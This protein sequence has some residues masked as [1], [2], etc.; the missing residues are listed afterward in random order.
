MF[1]R[2]KQPDSV[3]ELRAAKKIEWKP[4][5]KEVGIGAGALIIFV[6]LV[7]LLYP[8]NRSLPYAYVGTTA[9]GYRTLSEVQAAV[10]Q[11]FNSSTVHLSAQRVTADASLSSLGASLNADKTSEEI[12]SY[13]LWQRLLPFSILW[14]RPKIEKL[15]VSFDDETLNDV[16]SSLS[17]KLVAPSKN[18]S[19]AV[20]DNGDISLVS[21]EEGVSVTDENVKKAVKDAEYSIGVSN[22]SVTPIL[23]DPA[24]TNDTVGVVKSKIESILQKNVTIK[25]S[26]T[27]DT[28]TPSKK[29]IASWINIGDDMSLSLDKDAALAYANEQAKAQLIAAGTSTVT[30]VDGRETGRTAASTGRG[31]NADQL[32]NDLT[33][34]LFDDGKTAIT[35][36]F[37]TTQ[38]NVTYNRSYTYSQ[39]ALQAYIDEVTAGDNIE[40]AV[41]QLDGA[42]WTAASGATK[43]VV[44]ASTYKLFISL[45]LFEKINAG[46]LSWSSTVK[47]VGTSV[48]T[49]LYNT[50]I[51]S[52]NPCPEEWISEWGRSW[53]NSS[54]YGKGF[55]TATTFMAPDATHTS[56]G[57]LRKLL[58]GLYNNSLYTSADAAKLLGLMKSQVYRSGIPAG[59][60]GVVADKVG[61]LWDYL[62]DAAIVYHPRGT[63]VL[64]IM[65]KGESWAKIAAITKQL[66]NIM[67]P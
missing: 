48:D 11:S 40:I 61:F 45:L 59:S 37:V 42:G 1:L 26:M 39:A 2:R 44:S 30:M 24:V 58:I 56:A 67:Y 3:T 46:E 5:L 33:S 12:M 25:N 32:T 27:N 52:A 28:Y 65:T 49:C 50:I 51:Y 36:N 16:A 21:A 20:S 66:E 15:Y 18:G 7:Q 29:D 4:L 62:N 53:I 38:P 64:V 54:L 6:V 13:P 43:S 41:T 47:N 23:T 14:S 17:A 19:I 10:Q 60:E 34:A 63:Y 22:V 8:S 57:D 9:A 35:L 55:S 31:V